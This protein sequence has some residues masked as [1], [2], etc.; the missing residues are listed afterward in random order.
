MWGRIKKELRR[1]L[2]RNKSLYSWIEGVVLYISLRRAKDAVESSENRHLRARILRHGISKLKEAMRSINYKQGILV[3]DGEA[4]ALSNGIFLN[5]SGTNRY[6]KVAG[7][8]AGNEGQ[9]MLDF[10]KS[11]GIEVKTMIDLGANFGEISLY[12]GKENPSAKILAIEA[13]PDNFKIL[14]SNCHFQNFST[15]NIILLNEAV[16]NTKGF[17]E[18][19]KGVSAENIV[20]SSENKNAVR[21]EV[22]TE[23]VASD[24]FASFMRRF[25]FGELDFLKVDIEG[26]EPLLYDSLRQHIGDIKSILLEVGDKTDHKNYFPLIELL[27]NSGMECYERRSE[28]KFTSLA[29]VKQEISP[30]FASDLWFIR[31]L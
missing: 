19:T 14:E 11:K 7:D 18:I 9:K 23:K 12:F 22:K 3:A 8:T 29:Q 13:S 20:I 21:K 25:G 2:S 4:Y 24:T 31:K 1:I 15:K 26:S 10:L 30:S 6:L 16:G 5:L 28:N 27:W 17:V